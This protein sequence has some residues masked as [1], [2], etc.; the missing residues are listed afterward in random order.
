M[1]EFVPLATVEGTEDNGGQ[2]LAG[3]CLQHMI[4]HHRKSRED[5]PLVWTP[6][7]P[8]NQPFSF[9]S[10]GQ[11]PSDPFCPD[12]SLSLKIGGVSFHYM[13]SAKFLPSQIP[14]G[15]RQVLENW[16]CCFV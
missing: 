16:L 4:D 11:L 6:R 9:V 5:E 7:T 10:K 2:I 14:R 12:P 3:D 1:L 15:V 13:E 8:R